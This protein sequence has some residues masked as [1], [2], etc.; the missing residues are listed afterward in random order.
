MKEIWFEMEI[1]NANAL[2][3]WEGDGKPAQWRERWLAEFQEDA[4][5]LV[6]KLIDLF[7]ARQ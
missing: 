1:V 3:E 7:E 5:D 2:S 4:I 6:G